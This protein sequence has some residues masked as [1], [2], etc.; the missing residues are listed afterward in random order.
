MATRSESSSSTSSTSSRNSRL[1]PPMSSQPA[2]SAA[3]RRAAASASAAASAAASAPAS[4]AD[5]ATSPAVPLRKAAASAAA[6]VPARASPWAGSGAESHL[7]LHPWASQPHIVVAEQKDAAAIRRLA[8]R[9][10]DYLDSTSFA[11]RYVSTLGPE[12]Q[13]IARV[14]YYLPTVCVPRSM[15]ISETHAALTLGE[16]YCDLRA[17]FVS[18]SD[19]SRRMLRGH[20]GV[21]LRAKG[22]H[23]QNLAVPAP[24]VLPQPL[25]QTRAVLSVA[26]RTVGEYA[27]ERGA[28]GWDSLM[29]VAQFRSP[30]LV[31]TINMVRS[32]RQSIEKGMAT[33]EARLASAV[34]AISG[35][36]RVP[37]A[38]APTRSLVFQWV[39]RPRGR[40]LVP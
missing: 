29:R 3:S 6:A 25:T 37:S 33:V 10:A 38:A 26:V 12:I 16:E 22:T 5:R 14:L 39:R 28:V 8:R 17:V 13:L 31:A 19:D 30:R 23:L 2:A 36:P 4:L 27:L 34:R 40:L 18:L 20:G 9:V 32:W 21:G 11:A 35:Q 15:G 24:V 1:V 7:R